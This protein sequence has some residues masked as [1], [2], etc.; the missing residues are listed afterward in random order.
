MKV[1]V[2]DD[3][4]RGHGF[5]LAIC[6]EV[7]ELSDGGYAVT[8]VSEVPA[9]HEDNVREAVASCPERAISIS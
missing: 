9:E 4:C 2:D 8:L 3:A 1:H 5:C 6:P 7:F